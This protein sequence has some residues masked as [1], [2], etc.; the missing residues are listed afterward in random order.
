VK[1]RSIGDEPPN[2][3]ASHRQSP[4][5]RTTRRLGSIP[6]RLAPP[7]FCRPPPFRRR[8]V[9]C[10][11]LFCRLLRFF[12][13]IPRGGAPPSSLSRGGYPPRIGPFGPCPRL[14]VAF[15]A[16]FGPAPVLVLS[17]PEHLSCYRQE[18]C[19][20]EA[21]NEMYPNHPTVRWSEK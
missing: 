13:P 2:N 20:R 14:S 10:C 16:C 12:W 6:R 18:R 4:S 1:A 9:C 11:W 21:L 17:K 3:T 5:R 8:P 7:L 19:F 15:R